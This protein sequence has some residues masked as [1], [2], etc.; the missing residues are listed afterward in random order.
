ML[1]FFLL[2]GWVCVKLRLE[3][4][5]SLWLLEVVI[6]LIICCFGISTTVFMCEWLQV[7]V[8]VCIYIFL[9][10]FWLH[11]NPRSRTELP[12]TPLD[13]L[14]LPESIRA[15]RLQVSPSPTDSSPQARGS[16]QQDYYFLRSVTWMNC[17]HSFIS[18]SVLRCQTSEE[19][20][21]EELWH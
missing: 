1:V 9:L 20:S 6:R 14:Q 15:E 13:L 16:A 4:S 17:F 8:C 19:L 12:D 10:F 3:G 7:V 11:I 18:T 2:G 5:E 21:G